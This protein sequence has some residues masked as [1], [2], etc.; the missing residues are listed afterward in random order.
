MVKDFLDSIGVSYSYQKST[1]VEV[2]QAL[3]GASKSQKGEGKGNPEYIFISGGHLFIIENKTDIKQLEYT[4]N[5]V[6]ITEYPYR[7]DYAVNGAVH[8]SKHI[9][10]KTN[11]N[12]VI[13]IGVVGNK[14]YYEI[15]PYY[16]SKDEVRKL[17]SIK[18]F[19]D[20]SPENIEEYW[21]VAI[22][23][24]LPKEERELQEVTKVAVELHEDLRNYGNLSND[25]KAT[26]VSGIL[27]ALE[28]KTFAIEDLKGFEDDGAKDGD[29]I[30]NA[31]EM[32]LKSIE[33]NGR[34]AKY[35]ILLENFLYIKNDQTLNRINPSLGKTPLKYF[36]EQIEKKVHHHVKNQNHDIDILGKFYG[37]FVKYGGSDGNSLGI[38]LTPRH[39]TSLM[40]ELINIE[41]DDYVLDPACGSGAFLISAMQRM[42][43]QVQNNPN[44]NSQQKKE[45][46]EGIKQN[47]LYGVELQGKLFTIATTNMILRGDG[48]SNLYNGDMF[49]LP[50]DIYKKDKVNNGEEEKHNFIT[51][52][53]I[54][55]PYSQAKTKAL[56]HLSEI[57]FINTA[58]KMMMKGGKLA[59]I[60]P[61][62]T[63]VGKTKEEKVYK[64]EILENNTLETV[65][66]L[67]TD[68]FHGKGVNPC[69]C[70]FTAGIPHDLKKKRVNFVDFTDDGYEV[71][72]HT[73]LISNGTEKSKR[74]HLIDVLNG[75]A[76]DG[77]KFIV[78]TTIA[79]EDEWLHSF[80]YFNEEVPQEEDFE[81]TLADYLTF[82]VDMYSHG[83]R[84]LFEEGE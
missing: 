46:I 58:L 27:L 13:A 3:V 34:P 77:T 31:I 75:N 73:G 83:K 6:V 24:E 29:K 40:S 18:S 44:L 55:P 37:E 84:Y 39:I 30:Y 19:E 71:R 53:L 79:P 80:Y 50:E 9:V 28:Q 62:S 5:D 20:F 52:V 38:V 33:Y 26:V 41:P 47:Q 74:E 42:M 43:S 25:F 51:K 2:D 70:I 82:Q 65:I 1:I 36:V 49:H 12:E 63:M 14:H 56:S 17:N 81:K 72:K 15:Q 7:N 8:Y 78:K 59:A 22:K 16:V 10:E 32:Y 76:D 64:K 60:V 45:R 11:F 54:N 21:R 23:G 48:K 61:I 69:I 57:S 67:N 35:G 4:D 68:T 66:T